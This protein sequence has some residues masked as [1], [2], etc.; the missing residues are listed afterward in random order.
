[1]QPPPLREVYP[2]TSLLRAG[3]APRVV[4]MCIL[5]DASAKKK[6]RTARARLYFIKVDAS[7]VKVR[8]YTQAFVWL[9]IY[10]VFLCVY[11]YTH[12]RRSSHD[13]SSSR[14]RA[15]GIYII[16]N[17]AARSKKEPAIHFVLI[18]YMKQ[19]MA[20]CVNANNCIFSRLCPWAENK[21]TVFPPG[22]LR[23]KK[24]LRQLNNIDHPDE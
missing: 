11:I 6:K 18:F 14:F 10:R 24:K 17:L 4:V 2:L 9:S 22:Q 20:F 21:F 1:M 8:P 23:A 15:H 12:R 3:S 19:E 7:S 13:Y 5:A 16:F